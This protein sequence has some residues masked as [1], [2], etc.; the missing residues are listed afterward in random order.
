MNII[1]WYE[2]V[3]ASIAAVTDQVSHGGRLKSDRYFVW[4]EDGSNDFSANNRHVE[5]AVTGT[6]DLFTKTELDPWKDLYEVSLN[7]DPMISWYLSSIQFEEDT[8][9][10]HWEWRWEVLA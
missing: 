4:Q 1:L 6:T 2:R 7:A 10:W 5:K 8:G 3:I 9:F